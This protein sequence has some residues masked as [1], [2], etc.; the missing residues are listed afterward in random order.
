MPQPCIQ[1]FRLLYTKFG[2]IATFC[3]ILLPAE[4]MDAVLLSLSTLISKNSNKKHTRHDEQKEYLK[5]AVCHND[6]GFYTDFCSQHF[7][8][9]RLFKWE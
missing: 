2:N 9:F 3:L 1:V 7:S 6:S 4:K 5:A 8:V